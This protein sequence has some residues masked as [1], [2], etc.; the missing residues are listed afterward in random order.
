MARHHADLIMCR[1][2]PGKAIGLL[3]AAC[4]GKCPV[5]D[6]LVRPATECHICEECSISCK[7]RCII[8]SG[9]GVS[10]AFY[11]KECTQEEKHTDGCPRIIN[12]GTAKADMFYER[13]KY[14]FAKR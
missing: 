10:A 12:L 9:I 11:C 6:S 5:C 2:L 4:E 1:K 13:K 14:G 8:C 3:C 7:N